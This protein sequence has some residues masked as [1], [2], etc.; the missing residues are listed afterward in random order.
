M[1]LVLVC[2][3]KEIY[4]STTKIVLQ[5]LETL[6][7]TF[8]V[9]FSLGNFR[10]QNFCRLL[11]YLLS[12]FL[13]DFAVFFNWMLEPILFSIKYIIMIAELGTIRSLSDQITIISWSW[14]ELRSFFEQ[15]LDMIVIG[16]S[17]IFWGI[18]S[19]KDRE[20]LDPFFNVI[21]HFVC[22]SLNNLNSYSCPDHFLKD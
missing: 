17:I 14:P 7:F 9:S 12:L 22:V 15:N 5:V 11:R 21:C 2:Y 16:S 18:W 1:F 20:I 6:V 3:P 10:V 19:E 8:C 13:D 4:S